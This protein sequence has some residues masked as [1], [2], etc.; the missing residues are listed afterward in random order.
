MSCIFWFQFIPETMSLKPGVPESLMLR[1]TVPFLG[2]GCDDDV[3]VCNQ[4]TFNINMLNNRKPMCVNTSAIVAQKSDEKEDTVDYSKSECFSKVENRDWREGQFANFT[5]EGVDLAPAT[6]R[7]YL[8]LANFVTATE[9]DHAIWE[10]Y[11]TLPYEVKLF[12]MY[13]YMLYYIL[14]L[15]PKY[16]EA[17]VLTLMDKHVYLTD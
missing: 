7:S 11:K 5:I 8:V 16:F 12:N 1:L 15:L 17:F 4:L 13:T 14:P 9:G 10:G 6:Y 3:S 2:W